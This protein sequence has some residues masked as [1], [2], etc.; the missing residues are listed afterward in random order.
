YK[1]I[2]E[3]VEKLREDLL[4]LVRGDKATERVVQFNIQVF[5]RGGGKRIRTLPSAMAKSRPSVPT[6]TDAPSTLSPSVRSAPYPNQ[7][8]FHNGDA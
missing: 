3:R 7:A 4:E 5:P 1:T 6:A 8:R 2:L